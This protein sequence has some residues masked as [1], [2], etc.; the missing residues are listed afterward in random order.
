MGNDYCEYPVREQI[1]RKTVI[2][3]MFFLPFKVQRICLSI[4]YWALLNL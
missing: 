4:F 2:K 1:I 3:G